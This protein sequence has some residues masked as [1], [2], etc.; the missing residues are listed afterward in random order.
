MTD[1]NPPELYWLD[2]EYERIICPRD[3][4]RY[5]AAYIE[6]PLWDS[7][8]GDAVRLTPQTEVHPQ[9]ASPSGDDIKHA[10][11]TAFDA[12]EAS[13]RE[14]G[15]LPAFQ[16]DE[17]YGAVAAALTAIG[18]L[19]EDGTPGVRL[20][21]QT[22]VDTQRALTESWQRQYAEMKQWAVT[23]EDQRGVAWRQLKQILALFDADSDCM[24]PGDTAEFVREQLARLR[25]HATAAESS[26]TWWCQI[27]MNTAKRREH[28]IQLPEDAVKQVDAVLSEIEDFW[29]ST[30]FAW[31][32]VCLVESW[33]TG[34]HPEPQASQVTDS[35]KLASP[36]DLQASPTLGASPA[37][38]TSEPREDWTPSVGDTVTGLWSPGERDPVCVTGPYR[39]VYESTSGMTKHLQGR[40]LVGNYICLA[41]SLRP[42]VV[43]TGEDKPGG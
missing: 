5:V 27:A 8:P 7:L 22:E 1:T 18:A 43:P 9:T 33:R 32:I 31:K 11:D 29:G 25:E 3:D 37:A 36:S 30:A 2:G 40:P 42:V 12:L 39:G 13:I 4:G 20:V 15:A 41:D 24:E 26:A 16:Y 10:A 38:E 14:R 34:T 19:V 28:A 21:P 6:G 35:G 17:V 23:A